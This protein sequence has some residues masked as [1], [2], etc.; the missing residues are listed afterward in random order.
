[1]RWG[2]Q[3]RSDNVEDRRGMGAARGRGAA[4]SGGGLLL[5]L[6]IAFITGENPLVLLDAMSGGSGTSVNAP[7]EPGAAGAPSDQLGQFASAVL[8]S[9]EDV[10]QGVFRERGGG[11]QPP[12]MVLFTGA[13]DSGCGF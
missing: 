3:R 1:M 6:A 7:Q 5:V 10:W 4:I 11:Y 13:V 8:G 12:V 2:G 9:T